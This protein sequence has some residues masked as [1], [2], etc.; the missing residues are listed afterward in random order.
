M[1]RDGTDDIDEGVA[2]AFGIF[3]LTET[4]LPEAAK[5]G[6]VTRWELEDAIEDAGL[7][8][9]FRIDQDGDVSET[10]DDLLDS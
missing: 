2:K 4:S 3:A 5:M 6:G 8:D 1:V 7:G 10:I 9:V